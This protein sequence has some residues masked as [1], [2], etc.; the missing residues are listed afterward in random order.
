M[1]RG[2]G[3]LRE[4]EEEGAWGRGGERAWGHTFSHSAD[5][6]TENERRLVYWSLLERTHLNFDLRESRDNLHLS[7][8]PPPPPS[9][10]PLLIVHSTFQHR[11]TQQPFS[12]SYHGFP[13]ELP[14][15]ASWL[16]GEVNCALSGVARAQGLQ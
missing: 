8:P 1:R 14:S 15:H 3:A 16:T 12:C 7:L 6:I 5:W 13:P 11:P 9:V 2:Q 4:G 10:T